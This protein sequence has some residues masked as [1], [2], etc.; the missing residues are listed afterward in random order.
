MACTMNI[1]YS[2]RGYF[3]GSDSLRKY[4]EGAFFL[5]FFQ[6]QQIFFHIQ[7]TGIT[8]QTAV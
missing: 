7:P 6:F 1:S 8:G 2:H 5:L 4:T 3:G